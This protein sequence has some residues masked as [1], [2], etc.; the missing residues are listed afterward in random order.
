MKIKTSFVF[1]TIYFL[2]GPRDLVTINFEKTSIQ[3]NGIG[4][5][6][7]CFN[8]SNLKINRILLDTSELQRKH[9]KIV[10][11]ILNED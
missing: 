9:F 1:E 6:L 11:M 5:W 4:E 10:R 3:Q 8:N 2:G 7:L